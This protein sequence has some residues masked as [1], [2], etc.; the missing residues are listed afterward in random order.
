MTTLLI[1]AKATGSP[2]DSGNLCEWTLKPIIGKR[3]KLQPQVL[4]QIALCDGE[5]KR[6]MGLQGWVGQTNSDEKKPWWRFKAN[7]IGELS[8][9]SKGVG[10]SACEEEELGKPRAFGEFLQWASSQNNNTLIDQHLI[11][12]GHGGGWRGTVVL[13]IRTLKTPKWLDI[14]INHSAK[15]FRVP[16]SLKE[17]GATGWE[18]LLGDNSSLQ[19]REIASVVEEFFSKNENGARLGFVGFHSCLLA[20]IEVAYDLRKSAKYVLAS[21]D[22]VYYNEVPYADW[23]IKSATA[24]ASTAPEFCRPLFQLLNKKKGPASFFL[25]DLGKVQ[26]IK[27]RID[28][29]CLAVRTLAAAEA[30]E[31]RKYIVLTRNNVFTF[32]G[33]YSRTVDLGQFFDALAG[34]GSSSSGISSAALNVACAARAS[35]VMDCRY[36]NDE[37]EALTPSIAGIAIF[38]PATKSEACK[39]I[40]FGTGWYNPKSASSASSFIDESC[41]RSF[42]DWYWDET[43]TL[44]CP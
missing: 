11:F 23:L 1:Y 40:G 33:E 38:F 19:T 44:T 34:A 7:E 15:A 10:P 12:W 35:I 29:F 21:P 41:W 27:E 36:L 25:I 14:Y 9:I 37:I 13:A 43:S 3:A 4:C 6:D 22:F 16:F 8:D 32:G 24:T 5:I 20:T 18:N 26:A 30:S 39:T 17:S 2:Q 42:L 31:L 28:E